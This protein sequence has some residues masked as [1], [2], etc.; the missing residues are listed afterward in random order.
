MKFLFIVQGEGRGHMT[1]AVSLQEHLVKNGHEVVAVMVG[2]SERRSIPSFFYDRIKAPVS[3]YES[4]NFLVDNKN[5]GIRLFPSIIYN[6]KK[7]GTYINSIK[8]IHQ[9]VN[10]TKPDAIVNFYCLIGGLY[11]LF[12]KPNIPFYVTGHQYLLLH[13]DF[14]FPKVS[15]LQIAMLNFNTKITC[16]RAKKMLALSFDSKADQPKKNIYVVPPLLRKEVLELHPSNGN[17][18][19]SYVLNDG[20]REEITS[21]HSANISEELHLFGDGR[22]DTDDVTLH[23]NL[24]YHKINDVKFLNYMQNCK[25][26]ASTAGFESICEAMYLQKPILMVP[27]GGHIEQEINAFDAV[28]AGAGISDT[29]FDLTKLLNYIP[30]HTPNSTFKDWVQA[31]EK[32]FVDHLTKP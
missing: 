23:D 8:S 12:Y 26:Y 6:I 20:Y 29:R 19:L 13:K 25:G 27:T 17:Y 1:Q 9:K 4:P 28:R 18:I 15:K 5:K 7:F 11:S 2:K 32:M 21:W 14:E 22:F 16:F 24:Y 30:K 3:S 10:E 31:S